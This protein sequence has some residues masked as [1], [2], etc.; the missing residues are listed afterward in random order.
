MAGPRT[1]TRQQYLATPVGK[2]DQNFQGYLQYI[3]KAR[4]RTLGAAQT[5]PLGQTQP[6]VIAATIKQ[7]VGRLPAPL[8][9]TQIST[10]AQGMLDPVV[11]RITS[12]IQAQGQNAANTIGG[13]TRQLSADLAASAPA[14]VNAAYNPAEQATA[15][16]NA[17]LADRVTGAGTDASNA[18][19]S[20]LASINDPTVAA[21]TGT[22]A[23]NA[24][25]AGNAA[26]ATGNASLEQMLTNHATATDYANK[27][28]GIVDLGGVQQA[29]QAQGALNKQLGDSL[30]QVESQLP[31]IVQALRSSSDT[32][33]TNRAQL[34]SDLYQ[35]LTGQNITKATAKAGL[36]LDTA[37]AVAGA[38]SAPDATLSKTYGYKVDQYGNAIPDANGNIQPLPGY[39][40]GNNGTVVPPPKGGGKTGAKPPSA[41][42]TAAL[43]QKWHD[44]TPTKSQVEDANPDSNGNPVYHTKTVPGKGVP[45][46]Q[47]LQR[48]ITMGYDNKTA[49]EKLQGYYKRGDNGRGWLTNEE[50]GALAKAKV[51]PRAYTNSGV[52]YLR[53]D[54]AAALKQVGLLPP[55]HWI[56]GRT[57]VKDLGPVY[58]IEP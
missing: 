24:T 22:V 11:Q 41:T 13:Y 5:D 16:A 36:T 57:N 48:L 46:Q 15:A 27:L 42:Q 21:T 49:R 31:G 39:K 26:Y 53:P 30:T 56:Q 40:V 50:Q 47:A 9:N 28:P 29:G 3:A 51:T 35:A 23:Q 33:A 4:A 17:A 54:Q 58:I 6:G 45:F 12:G 43:I 34:A 10:Q 14:G 32:N 37:K 7:I 20:R 38:A 25:G 8:T 2:R 52:G 55:G 44:G 1:L 18:L 19:A